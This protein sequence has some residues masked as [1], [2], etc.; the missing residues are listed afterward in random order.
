MR[1]AEVLH[2]ADEVLLADRLAEARVVELLLAY[3]GGGEAAVIVRGIDRAGVGQR[4]DAPAHRAEQRVRVALLEVGA[5]AAADQQR[6]AGEGHRVVVENIGQ[7]AAGM[8][9]RRA[10]LEESLAEED[11]FFVVDEAA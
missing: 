3:A 7:A 2:V 9:R 1:E 4:E 10:R 5:A 6:V 8:A 11:L